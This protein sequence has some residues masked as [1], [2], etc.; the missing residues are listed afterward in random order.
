MSD[1]VMPEGVIA[2]G[3]SYVIAAYTVTAVGLSVYIW[4]LVSRLRN[5]G[6]EG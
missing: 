6:D 3:W 1:A 5:P 2:G 4:T